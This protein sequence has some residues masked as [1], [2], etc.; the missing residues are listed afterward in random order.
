LQGGP[1]RDFVMRGGLKLYGGS[2]AVPD[3]II[4]NYKFIPGELRVKA[5]RTITFYND[6]IVEHTIT[7]DVAGGGDTGRLRGGRSFTIK[8][9]SPGEFNF[10]CA[11]HPTMRGKII[12]EP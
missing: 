1:T 8:F 4:Q 2:G 5:G 11:L 10:H 6:D 7:D 3:G 12:V 9:S